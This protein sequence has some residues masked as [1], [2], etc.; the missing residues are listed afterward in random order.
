MYRKLNIS[1]NAITM[2]SHENW[3]LLSDMFLFFCA[4]N[5]DI[6]VNVIFY[7]GKNTE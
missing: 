5:L 6:S 4:E 2:P 3:K 7:I 1:I